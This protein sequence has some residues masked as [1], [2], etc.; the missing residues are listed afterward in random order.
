MTYGAWQLLEILRDD[1][2]TYQA[3]ADNFQLK[4]EL[5]KMERYVGKVEEAQAV[6]KW[7]NHFSDKHEI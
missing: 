3:V 1:I 4:G 7:I 6:V 2:N 5:G